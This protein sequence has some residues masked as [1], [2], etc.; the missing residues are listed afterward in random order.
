VSLGILLADDHVL[1][2]QALR[3]VLEKEGFVVRAEARDGQEAVRLAEKL[4]PDIAVLDVSMPMLNGLDAARQILKTNPRTKAI[5]LTMYTDDHYV[6]GALRAGVRGYVIKSQAAQ[7]LVDA[8]R[9][10]NQGLTYLSPGVSAAIVDA[11][12]TPAP[13]AT[14]PLTLRER[15]VLQLVAEGKT[16]KEIADVLALGVKSAESYRTRIMQK[17][18]IHTT[19]GLVRYAIRQGLIQA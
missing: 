16:S 12:L 10:V 17:L 6:L 2:R 4:R 15:Q 1:F 14:D 5:A 8:I 13:A 19:A 3:V 18:E 7:D 11:C 9:T